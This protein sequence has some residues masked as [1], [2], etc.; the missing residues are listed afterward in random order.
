MK[1]AVE[2]K[3]CLFVKSPRQPSKMKVID[4]QVERKIEGWEMYKGEGKVW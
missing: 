4:L 1:P 3:Q 2:H